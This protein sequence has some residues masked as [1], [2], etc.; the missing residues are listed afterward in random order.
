MIV[1]SN[2]SPL[3]ALARID[4]FILLRDLFGHVCVPEG[5][6]GEVVVAGAGRPG[7]R[8][9]KEAAGVWIEVRTVQEPLVTKGLFVLGQGEA[10]AIALALELGADLTLLDDRQARQAARLMGLSLAGTVGVLRFA[11]EEGKL[12]NWEKTL[13]ELGEQGFRISGQVLRSL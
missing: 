1:V 9:V 2:A 13:E 10:E 11:L 3:I 8:E 4:R 7:S 5:V 6:Y 12:E